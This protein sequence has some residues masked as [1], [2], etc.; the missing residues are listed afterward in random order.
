MQRVFSGLRFGIV[1]DYPEEIEDEVRKL[2]AGPIIRPQDH[3]Y[4]LS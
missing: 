1:H 2:R 3:A 4:N